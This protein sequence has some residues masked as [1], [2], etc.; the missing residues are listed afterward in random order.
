MGCDALFSAETT[1]ADFRT[2]LAQDFDLD[3]FRTA[4]RTEFEQAVKTKRPTEA[5]CRIFN[6]AVNLFEKLIFEAPS[7]CAK[8]SSL[9]SDNASKG[10]GNDGTRSL[11][12][13]SEDIT[14]LGDANEKPETQLGSE[15]VPSPEVVVVSII[16]YTAD[17]RNTK[18]AKVVRALRFWFEEA[19]TIS[20]ARK[21]DV[22]NILFGPADASGFLSVSQVNTMV[23]RSQRFMS[24]VVS[25]KNT[26][27]KDAMKEVLNFNFESLACVFS[28]LSAGF[29]STSSTSNVRIAQSLLNCY[30]KT[31]LAQVLFDL[32][33]QTNDTPD[34]T[35]TFQLSYETVMQIFV[36]IS[37]LASC[38]VN[39]LLVEKT[40][41]SLDITN[42]DTESPNPYV[43]FIL[44]VN[45]SEL[46]PWDLITNRMKILLRAIFNY[47]YKLQPD[48]LVYN[49]SRHSFLDWIT[50]SSFS[51][52]QYFDIDTLKD[53]TAFVEESGKLK[54]GDPFE[55]GVYMSEWRE[56]AKLPES[57]TDASFNSPSFLCVSMLM[58]QLLNNESFVERLLT[59]DEQMSTLDI[60][61]CVSSYVQHYA[62]KSKTND[63]ASRLC[64]LIL[65]KLT[66]SK[67]KWLSILRSR[68]INENVW[69]LCHHREPVVPSDGVE[70]TKSVL[71]YI[72][73]IIQIYLR[74]NLSRKMDYTNT[75][76]ALTVLYQ[77]LLEAEREPFPGIEIYQWQELCKS[78]VH[79]LKFTVKNCNDED[80]KLIVEE[81]FAIFDLVLSPS[82][83]RVIKKVSDSW[84]FGKHIVKSVNFDLLYT[85][86]EHYN[87][88]VETFRKYVVKKEN[89]K[90][91]ENSLDKLQEKF[92]LDEHRE[93]SETEVQSKLNELTLLQDSKPEI[94]AVV[95]SDF[96]YAET[97]KYLEALAD[98]IDFDKQTEVITAI[99][100]M[101]KHPSLQ[102]RDQH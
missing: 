20:R 54:L 1:D 36:V 15:P 2:A 70:E 8:E 89:F 85:F 30:F 51:S 34:L 56:R 78:L 57:K 82:F 42:I 22:V 14:A 95:A 27:Y 62:H 73:D 88:I 67:K 97:F 59:E 74:F 44:T 102:L 101:Y 72:V 40:S 68:R 75:K 29:G 48:L 11:N 81:I 3:A 52:N 25:S 49:M 6:E 65:L 13:D 47:F 16:P 41:L 86:L 99:D 26:I 94:T 5:L 28:S 69:K 45:F 87:W 33:E 50:G 39:L 83:D 58:Y 96:N 43:R 32:L 12:D 37:S 38:P 18:L 61:L 79:L 66:T 63:I 76:I 4:L 17:E 53:Y 91:V 31:D 92:A 90:R 100:F 64:L 46:A 23:F 10:T 21:V 80:T 84:L 35:N 9:D 77:V 93:R 19:C 98:Y 60:W 55:F 24:E 7:S 71:M